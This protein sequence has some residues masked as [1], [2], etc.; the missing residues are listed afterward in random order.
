MLRIYSFFFCIKIMKFH[1]TIPKIPQNQ[2][3]E[4]SKKDPTHIFFSSDQQQFSQRKKK[5]NVVEEVPICGF[6]SHR[7]HQGIK[8]T[9]CGHVGKSNLYLKMRV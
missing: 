1:H 5:M 6:C 3:T 9:I 4:I 2:T 7:H 8:C